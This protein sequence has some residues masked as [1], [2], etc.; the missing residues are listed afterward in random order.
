TVVLPYLPGTD[1]HQHIELDPSHAQLRVGHSLE[2]LL[3]R[4]SKVGPIQVIVDPG[5]GFYFPV[6]GGAQARLSY[7]LSM[8]LR[9]YTLRMYRNPILVTLVQ[10]SS[11]FDAGFRRLAEPVLSV[12]ALMGGAN[13]IRT[14]EVAAVNRVRRLLDETD[15]VVEA[16]TKGMSPIV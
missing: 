16:N 3:G 5:L 6:T 1:A 7:Q 10:A 8:Y 9:L 11:I 13:F 14:H 2:A 4:A 15:A 12:L